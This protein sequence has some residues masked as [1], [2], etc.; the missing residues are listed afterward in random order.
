MKPLFTLAAACLLLAQAAFA[1]S[2]PG[3][4]LQERRLGIIKGTAP[5]IVLFGATRPPQAT[6]SA[7]A[8]APAVAAA[9]ASPSTKAAAQ[10]SDPDAKPL[11][12]RLGNALKWGEP[13]SGQPLSA[14]RRLDSANQGIPLP[15]A[16]AAAS[17][18]KAG[19][20]PKPGG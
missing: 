5:G 2:E 13:P 17:A 20:R 7:A 4:T 15:S 12:E 1:Q 6:A 9:A 10:P 19:A 8:P 3:P 18:P 14:A 11:A 16:G